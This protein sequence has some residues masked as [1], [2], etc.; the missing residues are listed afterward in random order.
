[1]S[2]RTLLKGRK[3]LL[4]EDEM[5]VAMLAEAV[6][7]N[8]GCTVISAGHLEQATLLATEQALDAA[9]LDVN[10]HGNRSY[11]VADALAARGIPFIFA[12]GYGD[13]ELLRLYPTHLV[14]AKP[15]RP[16]DLIATLLSL[17]AEKEANS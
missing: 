9:V 16:E 14:L 12:T 13:V 8:E 3:I 10:L 6:L 1:M 15:Y 5:M 11:P 4:V 17:I 7:E 2:K